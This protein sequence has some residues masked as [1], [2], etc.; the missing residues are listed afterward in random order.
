MQS[1]RV[2]AAACR[3]KP[4]GHKDAPAGDDSADFDIVGDGDEESEY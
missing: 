1:H 4:I 2:L 3:H